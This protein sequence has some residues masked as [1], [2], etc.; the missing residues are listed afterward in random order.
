M[1]AERGQH[2]AVGDGQ[3][4][5][6]PGLGEHV[7]IVGACRLAPRSARYRLGGCGRAERLVRG[8]CGARPRGGG[9]GM[10]RRSCRVHGAPRR[11]RDTA[12]SCPRRVAVCARSASIDAHTSR[13]VRAQAIARPKRRAARRHPVRS[14]SMSR[15]ARPRPPEP[16]RAERN[17]TG[18]DRLRS[19]SSRNPVSVNSS[20]TSSI[21]SVNGTIAPARPARGDR[22][23][24]LAE[25]RAQ[26]ADDRVDRPREPV[27]DPGADRV[28]RRLADQRARGA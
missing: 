26:P 17:A 28:D 27:D 7:V 6:G 21:D 19:H 24:V 9:G 3:A 20:S 5:E 2:D 15:S 12:S 11:R 13:E 18:Y 10:R 1:P 16:S 25:L 22:G 14:P 4:A 23:G 8:A